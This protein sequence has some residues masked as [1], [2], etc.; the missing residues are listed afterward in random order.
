MTTATPI[1]R[2]AE[3]ILR[4]ESSQFSALGDEHYRISFPTA[5]LVFDIDHLRREHMEL[6]GELAVR[7]DLPGVR[8]IDGVLSF[9]T[10]NISS[11]RSRVER[12]RLLA[13]RS[14]M[15][16]DWT[17]FLEEFCQRVLIA[18]R[19]GQPAVNLSELPRQQADDQFMVD[20]FAF[21]RRHPSIIFGDGGAAKS[22]TALYL[23]GRM[24]QSG[25]CV[26]LFDWELAGEDH[27]ERLERLF[28]SVMPPITYA[29]CERPLVYE[30]DRLRRIVRDK[31]I[32]FAIFDSVAFACDGP[33][34][35]AEVAGKYF[36]AVRQI[37][38]GSLHIAHINKSDSADEKPFGSSFWHNGARAT[39]F[40]KRSGDDGETVRVGFFNKKSNL[41]RLRQPVGFTISF[42][43]DRTTFSHSDVAETPELAEKLS[44]RQRMEHLL[45]HGARAVDEIAAEIDATAETVTRTARRHKQRFTVLN[46]GKIAL[47]DRREGAR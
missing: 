25:L 42:T 8:A 22:Y 24:A 5:A 19:Q 18:E 14:R 23:G 40:T 9:A 3:R 16:L 26:A 21:P 41:G 44:V 47:F 17:G 38:V 32:D 29:R 28:G 35:A 39:W 12:A 27:R 30:A 36:R 13:A 37:G 31:C 6:I 45:R 1:D 7:C 15:N 34:E 10:F 43:A 4:E 46:G 33:P 11:A 20:R 2:E